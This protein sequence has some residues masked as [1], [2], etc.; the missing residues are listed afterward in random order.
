M[1]APNPFKTTWSSGNIK[2]SSTAEQLVQ[3]SPRPAPVGGPIAAPTST[4]STSSIPEPLVATL[5]AEMP[6][7]APFEPICPP[8]D[9]P[10]SSASPKQAAA[11]KKV[12]ASLADGETP[13]RRSARIA[14]L[15]S[16]S[17]VEQDEDGPTDSPTWRPHHA[18]REA[19]QQGEQ[20]AV[21]G[22]QA[23]RSRS[24]KAVIDSDE[25]EDDGQQVAPAAKAE[26]EVITLSDSSP[27]SVTLAASSARHGSSSDRGSPSSID[28]LPSPA[29]AFG[30]R[31]SAS[32]ASAALSRSAARAMADVRAD[33]AVEVGELAQPSDAESPCR[34]REAVE[35][36]PDVY[37]PDEVD[38][39]RPV[40]PL[41]ADGDAGMVGEIEREENG[42]VVDV[43]EEAE[44]DE[45]LVPLGWRYA[46]L[47]PS[48]YVSLT[49]PASASRSAFAVK[50]EEVDS[51]AP[52]GPPP[53]TNVPSSPQHGAIAGPTSS[54][55][56]PHDVKQEDDE[57]ALTTRPAVVPLP[58]EGVSPDPAPPTPERLA[59]PLRAQPEPSSTPQERLGCAA[60]GAASSSSIAGPGKVLVAPAADAASQLE[61]SSNLGVVDVDEDDGEV[62]GQQ[63]EPSSSAAR[64]VDV[65]EEKGVERTDLALVDELEQ[66]AAEVLLEFR[67]QTAASW[68][69]VS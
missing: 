31:V 15:R 8:A 23:P 17:H 24:A 9:R 34:A 37:G 29:R 28:T 6:R 56:S 33:D 48:D 13:V 5:A 7:R 46:L 44:P 39:E 66:I 12:S 43:Q 40:Q 62:V 38:E 27:E 35:A 21:A 57:T 61:L 50:P 2:P 16:Q 53:S 4:A 64:A 63:Q 20:G 32:R 42:V 59:S 22:G 58:L 52:L 47:S 65:E 14:A 49:P 19:Q 51:L 41:E 10:S 30:L 26:V 36:E 11:H 67:R 45:R 60:Y 68:C 55:T 54:S 1:V 3:T 18:G 69:A 25:D